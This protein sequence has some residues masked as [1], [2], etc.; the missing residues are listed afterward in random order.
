MAGLFGGGTPAPPPV[1]MAPPQERPPTGPQ[2]MPG[3]VA[4][5][6]RRR[7]RQRP[8]AE[9]TILYE[10]LGGDNGSAGNSVGDAGDSGAAAP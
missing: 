9:R 6:E 4:D 2:L 7:R 10:P 3:Q 5:A 8:I 1:L